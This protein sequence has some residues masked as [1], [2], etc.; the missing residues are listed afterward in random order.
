MMQ[1]DKEFEH[2]PNAKLDYGFDW[3]LWLASGETVSTSTWEVDS[4]LTPSSPSIAGAVTATFVEGGV[5]GSS[6]KITNT[7]VTDIGRKDSRTIKLYCK[8]R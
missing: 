3:S 1:V 6:Y 4:G 2:A 7:I 5:A 8:P